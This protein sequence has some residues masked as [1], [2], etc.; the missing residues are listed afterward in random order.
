M[1]LTSLEELLIE[2]V[3]DNITYEVDI[4]LL[5]GKTLTFKVR[6]LSYEENRAIVSKCKVKRSGESEMDS[7]KFV[8]QVALRGTVEPNFAKEEFLARIGV[9]T[10][11]EA[12]RKVLGGNIAALAGVIMR[13]SGFEKDGDVEAYETAKKL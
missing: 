8:E 12:I 3:E 6:T 7:L 5:N 4:K 2:G 9:N 1:G 10:P 11:E 13:V